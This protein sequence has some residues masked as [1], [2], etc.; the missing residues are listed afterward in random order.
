MT[1]YST[2][3]TSALPF[4]K[5]GKF[6]RGNLHGHT[7]NSDG[8]WSPEEY[9]RQYRQNGY[10]FVAITDHF[11]SQFDFPIT[12]TRAFRDETFTT[13]IGAELHHGRT[14]LDEIWHILAL[15]LPL[16]FA[17]Y[18]DQETTADVVKRALA[19]G[20][21]V[22]VPHPNGNTLT[23]DDYLSVAP[24]YA[25]EIFNG[26]SNAANDRGYSGHYIDVL[27][28]MGHRTG[29][30]AVD[31]LH[32]HQG[33]S[34][35]MSGW[36][37]VKAEELTPDALLSALKAGH[38]YASTGAQLYNI[39]ITDDNK[40]I[41]ECSPVQ[42]VIVGT[43]KQTVLRENGHHITRAEFDLSQFRSPYYRVT[44]IDQHGRR[45]WSNPIWV[46]DLA[47]F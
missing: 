34:D 19:S 21:F 16:D 15:G 31:D 23:I 12:D 3:T 18:D 40:L 24:V 37:Y 6:Y 8:M 10:D 43:Y 5:P 39:D 17:P 20:A 47:D 41:V 45:A 4:D 30:L 22:A 46:G 13:L 2:L 9:I 1:S 26:K 11:M 42:H 25:V 36:V 27:L 29:I 28:R 32:M 14:Q 35:F 38:Y 33:H 7:T 44:V